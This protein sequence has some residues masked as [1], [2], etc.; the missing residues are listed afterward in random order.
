MYNYLWASTTSTSSQQPRIGPK[1]ILDTC[2]HADGGALPPPACYVRALYTQLLHRQC[3]YHAPV[4]SRTAAEPVCD[5]LQC[6]FRAASAQKST[7]VAFGSKRVNTSKIQYGT[8]N[9]LKLKMQL[10]L[11][12]WQ[13][14]LMMI[15]SGMRL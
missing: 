10:A 1:V 6:L 7:K 2:P 13:W 3:P 9:I 11:R 15:L 5:G 4:L 8:V 14:K 12:L